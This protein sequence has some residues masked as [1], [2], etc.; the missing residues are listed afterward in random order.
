MRV[1]TALA[2]VATIALPA[3]GQQSQTGDTFNWKGTIPAG[4]WIRIKNLNG[5]VTVGA[6]SGDNVE[7]IATKHWRRGDP[8]VVRFTT[9]NYGG[10]VVICALWGENS[11]C[12][13]RNYNV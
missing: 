11:S 7:V 6:A 3:A 12:N 9:D 2:L 5:G 8:S 13:E 4:R 1:L 10:D